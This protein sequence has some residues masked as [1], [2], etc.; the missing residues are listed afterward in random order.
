MDTQFGFSVPTNANVVILY[1]KIYHYHCYMTENAPSRYAAIQDS[2][3]KV[4]NIDKSDTEQ[5]KTQIKRVGRPKKEG[6]N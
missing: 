4:D 5:V 2:D 3:N 6:G 1:N